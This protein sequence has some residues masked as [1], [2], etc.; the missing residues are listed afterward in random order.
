MSERMPFPKT[1]EATPP[2]EK[3]EILTPPGYMR[4]KKGR[5]VKADSLDNTYGKVEST[6]PELGERE[7]R[8]PTPTK[9]DST[10]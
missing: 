4:D 1:P 8:P 10:E 6:S 7:D 2:P 9:S 5:L 3:P